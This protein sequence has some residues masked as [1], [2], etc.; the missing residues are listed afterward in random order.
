MIDAA[1]TFRKPWSPA[2]G[3]KANE[4]VGLMLDV[5]SLSVRYPAGDSM[6]QAVGHVSLQVSR[7]EIVGLVGES[8]C[9]KSSVLKAIAGLLSPPIEVVAEHLI[10]DGRRLG[11]G[12]QEEVTAVRGRELSVIFQDPI[13]SFNPAWTIG[14]QFRRILRLHR[15]D[16]STSEYDKEIVRL[17]STVGVDGRGKLSSYPFQFSQGQ[18][19]RIMIAL[20]SVSSQL[21]VLLAD[22]PTTSLDVTTEA[23][24]LDLLRSLR[25]ERGL[26]VVL[27]T[28][29]LPVV[30]QL[31]DRVIVMY[32]G[33]VVEEGN[34]RDVFGDPKHP[35]TEQ[36]L[37]AIPSF[38]YD[39]TR[40]HAM[41]GVVPDLSRKVIGCPF[42]PRCDRY[43][44]VVCDELEPKLRT[45]EGRTQAAACHLYG[46]P[47]RGT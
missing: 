22:E 33:R 3:M 36:L 2:A 14:S 31:C 38:P 16:L 27:V 24:V 15:S 43:L 9:G 40:L 41:R 5:K 29:N 6:V 20:A 21:K 25:K 37:R 12:A 18:L 30:A 42:A 34:V 28:H 26:A 4:V 23:Q 45:V 8:G 47:D 11:G 19:Q 32:A 46:R 10:L 7:G 35:Y 17:L 39:G 13:N 44:G 1:P